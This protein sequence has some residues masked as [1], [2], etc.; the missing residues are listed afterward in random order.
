MLEAY[1]R[2]G[3]V[4]DHCSFPDHQVLRT[5]HTLIERGMVELR[6]ASDEVEEPVVAERLFSH[7]PGA[8]LREWM[9]V[10]ALDANEVQ[11]ARLLVVAADPAG[12]REFRR[13][14]AR[15][16]GAAVRDSS[17]SDPVDRLSPRDRRCGCGAR[18]CRAAR[19]LRVSRTRRPRWHTQSG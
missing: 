14:I 8:R 2:V 12:S 3:D 1:S 18:D 9:G 10:D 13:L 17:E 19:L 16:P 5:L 15:L 4:V 11:D 7:A 6:D